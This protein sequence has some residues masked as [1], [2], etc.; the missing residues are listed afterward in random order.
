[1][2]FFPHHIF[3]FQSKFLGR[4]SAKNPFSKMSPIVKIMAWRRA[5]GKPLS[6]T[7]VAYYT[8]VYMRHSASMSYVNP[9]EHFILSVSWIKVRY[10]L[11]KERKCEYCYHREYS[12]HIKLNAPL[13]YIYIYILT[14]RKQ[15]MKTFLRNLR[16]QNNPPLLTFCVQ[17]QQQQ[18]NFQRAAAYCITCHKDLQ[19]QHYPNELTWLTRDN[20][21]KYR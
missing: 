20:P 18:K 21:I 17:H 6:N 14:G 16:L 10:F 19:T 2:A 15:P 3:S 1:M 8:D 12:W 13:A 7:M 4:L 5:G 9:C 11:V